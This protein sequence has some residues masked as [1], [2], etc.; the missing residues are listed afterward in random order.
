MNA[1]IFCCDDGR[2]ALVRS[3]G[4]LNGID[5]LEVVDHEEPVLAERQRLLRLHFVK[6][7]SATLTTRLQA[8]TPDGVR[9]TGGV[10]VQGITIDSPVVLKAGVLEVHVTPRGDFSPYTLSLVGP[11]GAPLDGLDPQLASVTFSFKIECQG[12]FDCQTPRGCLTAPPTEPDI[13]YLAKDYASFR[14]LMLDRMAA[15]MPEFQEPNPADLGVVLVELLAYVA[16]Q[17]SYRQDAIA[18]EA[19]LGTAR[20]RVSVR[21]HARLVDYP[22]H[23]GCNARVWVHLAGNAVSLT[24]PKGTAL[25][26]QVPGVEPPL[27]ADQAAF[28]VAV[29]SGAEVF[30]TMHDIT[31]FAEHDD[32]EFYTWGRRECCLPRGATGATLKGQLP[33]LQ[34]GDVLILE[35]MLDPV[36]GT[37]EDADPTHRHAVRL[38][39][40]T[41]GQD[42]VGVPTKAEPVPPP[43]DVTE[44][45]WAADDALPFALCLSAKTDALHGSRTLDQ[46]SVAH[47]NIVLADHG[48]TVTQTLDPVPA[49]MLESGA[50]PA[51]D[52]CGARATVV[53][54]QQFRPR[55][56]GRPLT[57][58]A[59][60]SKTA[61]VHGRRQRLAFDPTAPAA[62]VLD[63]DMDQVFPVVT[64][65]DT[66]HFV[67][68]LP[69]R[70]LLASDALAQD[71]VAE[72]EDDGGATLRFGDDQ[73][74]SRPAAQ[75]VFTA[76]YRVGNGAA[77]NVG[78]GAIRLVA[79]VPGGISAVCNPLPARGGLEPELLEDVRQKAPSAFRVPQRAVTGDDYAEVAGRRRGVSQAAANVRWTGSWRTVFVSVDR[80]G[81][82]P[83]DTTF[84]EEMGGFLE[85]FRMAGQDVEVRAPRFVF[86]EVEL[87]VCIDPDYFRGDVLAALLAVLGSGVRP[88]GQRG[89]FHPDNFTFGQPV[90]LSRLYAAAQGV[91]GVRSVE[92]TTLRPLGTDDTAALATG[93]LTVGPLE[94]ARLDNDPNFPDRGVL[95]VIPRGGR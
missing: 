15:L 23:D 3:H 82:Q 18:T 14:Q 57:Q 5:F 2:R 66:A 49:D 60:V 33:H 52:R 69:Q 4:T 27:L 16:D 56:A 32:I 58:A 22:M 90:Y 19:Y 48:R 92:I 62:A 25:L 26:T 77:G 64:L 13:D 20:R 51:T 1:R 44:V 72:V 30:E 85:R 42:P 55:L 45:E 68:W 29:A 84:Q 71:F 24:V 73:N 87:A 41:A 54:P 59:V 31:L 75:T 9:L 46:V 91:E 17:L 34:P 35:E 81:G 8:L 47:G 88:D 95:R 94:I 7:P 63:W 36:T 43:V 40:V 79:G 93:Q 80:R 21:R 53:V 39:K 70:D 83:V 74:G 67:E 6:P 37:A 86:L 65:R 11:G 89:L 61:I 38:T 50:P 78:A 10:R 12:D 76:T 28:D